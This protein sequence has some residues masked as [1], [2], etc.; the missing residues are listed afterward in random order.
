MLSGAFKNVYSLL[1]ESVTK[2]VIFRSRTYNIE[3]FLRREFKSDKSASTFCVKSAS[4]S[5]VKSANT[6]CIKSASTPALFSAYL[7]I[8]VH[9]FRSLFAKTKNFKCIFK[10]VTERPNKSNT[11]MDTLD[12]CRENATMSL[13]RCLTIVACSALINY[14]QITV[15]HSLNR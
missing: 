15:D 13:S 7:S 1:L 12:D 2:S 9:F 10:I 5:C 14:H 6:F 3:S 11:A 8:L 4:T